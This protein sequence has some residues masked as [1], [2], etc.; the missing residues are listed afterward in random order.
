M[1][2]L[3]PRCFRWRCEPLRPLNEGVLYSKFDEGRNA[4]SIGALV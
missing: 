3:I 2:G 4:F 1:P